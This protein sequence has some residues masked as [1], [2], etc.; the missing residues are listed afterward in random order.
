MHNFEHN[1]FV[2]GLMLKSIIGNSKSING[3]DLLYSINSYTT[4]N[5][6]IPYNWPALL[7]ASCLDSRYI[8]S[9]ALIML[10]RAT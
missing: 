3:S 1:R 4:I 9:Y 8:Y 6:N 10:L 7:A 5:T 2:L